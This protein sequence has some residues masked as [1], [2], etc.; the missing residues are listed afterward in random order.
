M[1]KAEDLVTKEDNITVSEEKKNKDMSAEGAVSI[2]STSANGNDNKGEDTEKS[3]G[4]DAV[5]KEAENSV[6]EKEAVNNEVKTSVE[7]LDVKESSGIED[8]NV[9]NE[10]KDQ[11]DCE[12]SEDTGKNISSVVA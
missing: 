2:D 7:D 11:A 6:V 5:R 9:T 4:N 10:T 8:V 3:A 1:E 12:E